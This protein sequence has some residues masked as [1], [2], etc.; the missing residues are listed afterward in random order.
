MPGKFIKKFIRNLPGPPSYCKCS[1]LC[2]PLEVEHVIPN[3]FLKRQPR[4]LPG[5][6]WNPHNLYTCCSY[7]NRNKADKLYGDGFSLPEYSYH[8]GALARA[9][10][11]MT[12][13]YDLKVRKDLLHFW[14]EKHHQHPPE[15]F[16]FHRNELIFEKTG[17]LNTYVPTIAYLDNTKPLIHSKD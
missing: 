14:I 11:H 13:Y 8:H 3:G 7:I 5:A 2:S 9:C 15:P 12:E 17:S 1:V 4:T 6:R 10:L 16:E